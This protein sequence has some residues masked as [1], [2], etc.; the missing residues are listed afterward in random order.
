[1]KIPLALA[2]VLLVVA[3]VGCSDAVQVSQ[4]FPQV[5]PI[6]N[7]GARLAK[8]DGLEDAESIATYEAVLV[9]I[10]TVCTE[11]REQVSLM[12]FTLVEKYQEIGFEYTQLEALTEIGSTAEEMGEGRETTC[13]DAYMESR[14]GQKALADDIEQDQRTPSW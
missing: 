8:L 6:P 12:A 2:G 14:R 4:E 9:D 1:M 3:G 13:F 10:E 11:T 7:L 5:D